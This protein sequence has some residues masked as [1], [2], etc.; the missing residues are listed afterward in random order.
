MRHKYSEIDFGLYSFSDYLRL[1]YSK[2]VTFIFYRPARLIR[3]PTRMR[4]LKFMQISSGFTS[5]FNCR[6]EAFSSNAQKTLFF[7]KDVSIGDFCHITAVQSVYIGNNVLIA[8][9]VFISDHDHG[10]RDI[11]S[12][13]VKPSMRD[14]YSSPVIVEENVW[15]GEHVIILK[16]VTIGRNSIIG[17]GA[18]IT[19]SVPPYSVVVGNP[20]R[21]IS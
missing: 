9:S 20:G 19:K 17:A 2:V 3:K 7:G 14:I 5:G 12:L 8:S 18:V 21:V 15:I 4:G 1:I 11:D 13:L 10:N 6:L 16:G